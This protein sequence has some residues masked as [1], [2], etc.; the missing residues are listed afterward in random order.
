MKKIKAIILPVKGSP[1][2]EEVTDELETYQ[3][4]VGGYT[5]YYGGKP[6]NEYIDFYGQA[7]QL[8][9][10][11]CKKFPE[12]ERERVYLA[13]SEAATMY[14]F[15]TELRQKWKFRDWC[16]LRI[17]TKIYIRR[18]KEMR[19]DGELKAAVISEYQ[20]GLPVN[21]IAERHQLD[22][23][24][25]RNNIS[26]WAKKGLVELRQP[27]KKKAPAEADAQKNNSTPKIIPPSER[28]I[29]YPLVKSL[30]IFVEKMSEAFEQLYGESQLLDVFAEAGGTALVR[31]AFE[32]CGAR[33]GVT[34]KAEGEEND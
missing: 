32:A 5:E 9:K 8:A 14:E 15:S 21:E 19:M 6:L 18:Q 12:A 22:P 27:K 28:K 20:Q 13:A 1:R 4:L 26:R 34:I 11:F 31:L 29:K 30:E 24:V 23:H 2:L 10:K 7:T 33:F 25:T 3:E 17:K 16:Y